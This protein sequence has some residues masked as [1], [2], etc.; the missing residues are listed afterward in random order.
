MG[1]AHSTASPTA[2]HGTSQGALQGGGLPTYTP[3]PC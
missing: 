2:W 3:T 1:S